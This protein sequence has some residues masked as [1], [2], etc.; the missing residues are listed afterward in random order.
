[1]TEP[2]RPSSGTEGMDFEAEF[3]DRCQKEKAFW[4]AS[5]GLDSPDPAP[6]CPIHARAL[7]YLPDDPEFPAEWIEDE[8]GPRCT[9][10][11][12]EDVEPPLPGQGVL[13]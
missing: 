8:N 1:M 7:M 12:P 3:C 11:L 10:F 13:V 5:Y 2:Y 9:A 6:I 4:E